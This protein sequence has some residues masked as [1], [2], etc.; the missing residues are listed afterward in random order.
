MQWKDSCRAIFYCIRKPGKIRHESQ[1]LLS[2]QTEKY[3]RTGRSVVYAHSSN[4]SEWNI[5]KTWSSQEWKSDELMDDRTGRPVV[6]AQHTHRFIIENDET[7][8]YSEAEPELSSGFRSLLHR[9][10][11]R[12]R[13]RQDQS[14]KDATKD[15]DKHP[16]IRWMFMSSTLQASVF[17]ER[18]TQTIC[19]PSKIQKISQWNRCS[20]YL[21]NQYPNNQMR[22]MEWKQ[23]TGKTLHGSICLW[24]VMNKS[25]VSCTQRSTCSQILYCV[26]E[27]RT[28]TLNQI[29]HGKTDWRD[30]KFHQN[31]ELFG[32]NWWWANGIRVEHLPRIHH[33]AA[34]PQSPR[35]SVKIERNT[36]EIYWTDHLHVD[37]QR[38]LMGI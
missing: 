4:Y 33:I 30:S 11:D 6:N 19:I 8:S 32:Q 3:D 18:I 34:L 28:R 7:N 26:L 22:S 25:S 9:V 10:N 16:V 24:L 36:K 15:S 20:I 1:T 12:V 27:R 14:S 35:G 37:V 2:P 5:D 31:I 23:F 38:H 13:K 17:M 21:R 29:L